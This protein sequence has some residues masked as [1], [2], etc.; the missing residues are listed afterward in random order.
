MANGNGRIPIDTLLKISQIAVIPLIGVM[1][2]FLILVGKL[3]TRISI[4]ESLS[5]SSPQVLSQ[6]A[7]IQDRQDDLRARLHEIEREL[8]RHETK[9]S[10][11][12]DGR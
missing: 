3:D 12:H 6:L 7:I 8:K 5:L 11:I 10:R 2:W 9:D 1:L 4:L